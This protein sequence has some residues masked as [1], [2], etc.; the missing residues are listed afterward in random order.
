ML[1]HLISSKKFHN[2]FLY[3]VEIQTVVGS[4]I[5]VADE[6]NLCLLSFLDAKNVADE[7]QRL[8]KVR[9]SNI[10]LGYTEPI[11]SIQQELKE[12]FQHGLAEFKTPI[13][14]FDSLFY[15]TVWQ[16]LQMIP[17]GQTCSYKQIAQS[18]D[19]PSAFRAVARANA[20]NRYAILIPCHR[21][22]NANGAFGGYAG[23]IERKKWLLHHEKQLAIW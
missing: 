22:I 18:I 12:Y 20:A 1:A 15:Q 13:S 14:L 11:V 16:A 23:G 4:M 6:Q 10:T 17:F 7:L 21:V 19:H 3:A 8:C 9:S 5:A 2:N